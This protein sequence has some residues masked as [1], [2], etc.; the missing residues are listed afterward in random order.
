L[1]SRNNANDEIH[2]P[3]LPTGECFGAGLPVRASIRA[4]GDTLPR[5]RALSEDDSPV[6]IKRPR[7]WLRIPLF[8][9][10]VVCKAEPSASTFFH[11]CSRCCGRYIERE[12]CGT[13]EHPNRSSQSPVAHGAGGI[14]HFMDHLSGPLPSWWKDLG[15]FTKWLDGSKETIIDGVLQEAD[16]RT[17]DQ[18]AETRDA[19]ETSPA[20]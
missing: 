16:G 11:G 12:E 2:R 20:T 4:K 14:K 19:V 13:L 7:F 9:A 6:L 1:R 17:L 18:L 3:A 8:A 15:S 10:L 5:R